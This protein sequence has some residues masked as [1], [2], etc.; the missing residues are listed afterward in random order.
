[1]PINDK[2]TI[3]ISGSLVEKLQSEVLWFE[4]LDLK[5]GA[6]DLKDPMFHRDG[7]HLMDLKGFGP[8]TIKCFVKER[9]NLSL[10]V[11]DRSTGFAIGEESMSN[12]F[13]SGNN[14]LFAIARSI[15]E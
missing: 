1:M 6:N 9:S 8:G 5:R 3:V 15:S 11:I 2:I 12:R 7:Q 4:S 13:D 14:E 10:C